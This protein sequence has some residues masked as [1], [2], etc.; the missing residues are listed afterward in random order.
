MEKMK[1]DNIIKVEITKKEILPKVVLEN[2]PCKA[3]IYINRNF[4]KR[5]NIKKWYKATYPGDPIINKINNK[6]DFLDIVDLL[7]NSYNIYDFLGVY[8]SLLRERIFKQLVIYS[9]D[10]NSY[11]DFYNLFL[12]SRKGA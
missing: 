9:D 6:I 8:D 11:D 10:L 1:N 7:T 5:V 4:L 2:G 3:K 12:E